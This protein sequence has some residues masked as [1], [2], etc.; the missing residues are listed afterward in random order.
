MTAGWSIRSDK[1]RARISLARALSKLGYTSRSQARPLIEAG[2]VSVNG[3]VVKDPDRK[4]DIERDRVAVSG[5]A[6][7]LESLVYLA[8]HKPRGVVTTRSDERGRPTVFDLLGGAQLPHLGAVGRLDMDSEGLLLFTNDTRWAHRVS[9]PESHVEKVYHVLIDG[10]PNER[11]LTAMRTGV[12]DRGDVLRAKAAGVLDQSDTE[13]W[14]EIVLDEGKN[15]HIRRM[16]DALGVRV[17]RLKRVAIGP[18]QLG[19]LR[20]GEFRALTPTEV[21]AL[22]S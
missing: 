5:Q 12:Q 22:A 8:M 9:S 3:D 21:A 18:L 17:L 14:L 11:L 19:K 4:I 10:L 20:A 2:N 6:L 13:A 7:A 1:G 15:R 16:L